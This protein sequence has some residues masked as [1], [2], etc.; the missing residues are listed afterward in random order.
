MLFWEGYSWQQT[1][2]QTS[3]SAI[4][5]LCWATK[6]DVLGQGTATSVVRVPLALNMCP[7]KC[8]Q[9]WTLLLLS[10]TGD[11]VL[12]A[13]EASGSDSVIRQSHASHCHRFPRPWGMRFTG[14][15]PG[16]LPPE[17]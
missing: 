17:N 1:Q 13:D 10:V 7:A 14:G 12:E 16:C 6:T 4:P 9:A 8:S 3:G 2:D 15:I 5:K 11:S